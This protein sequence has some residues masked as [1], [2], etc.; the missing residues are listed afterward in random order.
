MKN[1]RDKWEYTFFSPSHFHILHIFQVFQFHMFSQVL[2]AQTSSS[3]SFSSKMAAQW[4]VT[5]IATI[6]IGTGWKCYQNITLVTREGDQKVYIKY[7][8]VADLCG[9]GFL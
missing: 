7:I 9:Q 4:D 5:D 6:S 2:N 3:K 1:V 8:R